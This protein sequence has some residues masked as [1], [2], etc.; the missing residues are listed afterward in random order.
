MKPRSTLTDMSRT[1]I[2]SPTS[3]PSNPSDDAPLDGD[4][5]QSSPGAFGGRSGHQRGKLLADPRLEKHRR[6]GLGHLALDLVGGIFCFGE[7]LRQHVLLGETVRRRSARHGGLQQTLREQIGVAAIR[8]RGV[9]VVLD[10]ETEVP[11]GRGVGPF[12]DV[13]ARSQEFDHRQGQIGEAQRIG[14]TL[15]DEKF[16]EGGGIRGVRQFDA[17][18]QGQCDNSVPAF[19]RAHHATDRR[20][21]VC[22]EISGGHAVGGDHEILDDLLGAIRRFHGEVTEL[23]AVKQRLRLDRFQAQRAIDVSQR[24]QA[25]G[26]PGPARADSPPAH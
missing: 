13:F 1:R 15:R 20:K 14:G 25:S 7:V 9:C 22:C 4:G 11:R 5:E 23:V 17:V 26:R 12:C 8:G 18:L 10:R 3:A 6:R 2:W 16:V 24:P 19:R 21:L